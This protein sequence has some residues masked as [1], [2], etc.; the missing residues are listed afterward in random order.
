LVKDRRVGSNVFY[1]LVGEWVPQLLATAG[2]AGFAAPASRRPG[3]RRR[4]RRAC[5]CPRC[6]EKDSSS[7][8]KRGSRTGV[9]FSA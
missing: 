7:V 9:S 2:A 5:P 4:T 6:Q 3:G 8:R 1:A